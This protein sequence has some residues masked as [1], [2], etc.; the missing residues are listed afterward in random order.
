MT[1]PRTARLLNARMADLTPLSISRP[2]D[3]DTKKVQRNQESYETKVK[4]GG[5]GTDDSQKYSFGSDYRDVRA[6]SPSAVEEAY[7]VTTK[8]PAAPLPF[9]AKA[10]NLETHE[11]SIPS[12]TLDSTSADEIKSKVSEFI[13]RKPGYPLDLDHPTRPSSFTNPATPASLIAKPSSS[14]LSSAGLSTEQMTNIM[15]K[16]GY[17]PTAGNSYPSDQ[18]ED[19][20]DEHDTES[21]LETHA[22]D[23]DFNYAARPEEEDEG[24]D[25]LQSQFKKVSIRKRQRDDVEDAED[26]NEAWQGA[27]AAAHLGGDGKQKLPGLPLREEE[28]R[29]KKSRTAETI[30]AADGGEDAHSPEKAQG[31]GV[32]Q[33]SV[34]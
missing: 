16:D 9:I 17:R 34:L 5:F 14:P 12:I 29:G 30:S 24:Y 8:Y 22:G 19:A 26:D 1:V 2:L 18:E 33:K 7:E 27:D 6:M 31:G 3:Q 23:D 11:P 4:K 32:A 21:D 13:T 25:S 28:H 20:D 15:K 10:P